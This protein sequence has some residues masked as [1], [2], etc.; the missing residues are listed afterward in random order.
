MSAWN[1][2]PA[3]QWY[4]LADRDEDGDAEDDVQEVEDYQDESPEKWTQDSWQ[5]RPD[6]TDKS[7][8]D[9]EEDYKANDEGETWSWK[10]R[11]PYTQPD[12]AYTKPRQRGG[13]NYLASSDGT[14]FSEDT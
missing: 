3:W 9:V 10:G 8:Q 5:G 4:E 12:R 13:R 14:P 11:R 2:Y 6:W 1:E 7:W